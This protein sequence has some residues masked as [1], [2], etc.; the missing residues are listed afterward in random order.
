MELTPMSIFTAWLGV[1]SISFT[2]ITMVL[3]WRRRGTADGFSSV[4]FVLPMLMTSCWL[5][6]GY[7]TN[8]NTN[9]TINTINIAFF[10]FYIAAFAYYQPKRVTCA[11][12]SHMYSSFQKRAISFGHTEY[13][14]ASF[15]YAMFLL[16]IQWLAFGLLTGNQYIAIANAA[17]LI[18]NV[19]TISL[20]FIYPPLTW[21]VPIIGTGPQLKEK[22]KE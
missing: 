21:R 11:L 6:H 7:M 22:K 5:R 17:A 12:P 19:V 1:F 14:P 18:V 13:L 4:N 15:Q 20:Y 16:I 3:D 2:L 10:I 8:D 9:I